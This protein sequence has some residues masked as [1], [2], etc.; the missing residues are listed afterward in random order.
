MA[1]T[2]E[3]SPSVGDFFVNRD[4]TTKPFTFVAPPQ[5][6]YGEAPVTV[7]LDTL[8][9]ASTDFDMTGQIV[10]SV[11]V[12]VSQYLCF[13]AREEVQGAEAILEL[14]AGCGLCGLACSKLG[15][16]SVTLTDNEPEVLRVL[17][18]SA[19]YTP[20]TRVCDLDWGNEGSHGRLEE[21]TGRATWPVIIG[22]DVIYWSHAVPLLFDTVA[23]LLA[24]GGVFILGFTNRRNGLK[25]AAEAAATSAGLVF[26]TVDPHSFLPDPIPHVFTAQLPLVT[27]YRMRH[28]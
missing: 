9:A 11:S 4:Y 6:K 19:A 23:K 7:N 21:S 25:E 8:E 2:E 24:P 13:V 16:A 28:K 12:L 1:E 22:A 17:E 20:H 15:S 27:L 18:R 3:E 10:W 26:D 14:G 5:C